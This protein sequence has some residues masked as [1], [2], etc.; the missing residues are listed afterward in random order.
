[1]NFPQGVEIN[2]C[3][4]PIYTGEVLVVCLPLRVHSNKSTL[5][6]DRGEIKQELEYQKKLMY[7]EKIFKNMKAQMLIQVTD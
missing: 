4:T 6:I 1:D 3:L 2:K 7:C 5:N